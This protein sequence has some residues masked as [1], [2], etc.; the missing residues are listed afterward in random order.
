MPIFFIFKGTSYYN[1][2]L[3]A[4]KFHLYDTVTFIQIILVKAVI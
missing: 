3:K 1:L 4:V 2:S